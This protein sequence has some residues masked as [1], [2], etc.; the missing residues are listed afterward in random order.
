MAS[1]PLG[2]PPEAGSAAPSAPRQ[3][4]QRR[5]DIAPTGDGCAAGT[6]RHRRASRRRR[7]ERGASGAMADPRQARG[8]GRRRARRRP[9]RPG[10]RVGPSRHACAAVVA[11]GLAHPMARGGGRGRWRGLDRHRGR[12]RVL[13]DRGRRAAARVSRRPDRDLA[14]PRRPR[15]RAGPRPSWRDSSTALA[16]G[17]GSGRPSE[18]FARGSR[19]LPTSS[20]S[21]PSSASSPRTRRSDR[22]STWRQ[23][24]GRSLRVA[25]RVS[26]RESARRYLFGA[27][28]S[29]SLT[30]CR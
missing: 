19:P 7:G 20:S 25:A 16:R 27:S 26:A 5:E 18:R 3:R 6:G 28:R 17:G 30:L 14:R 11:R 29:A 23:V 4:R 1:R 13:P 22:H 10:R 2:A 9:A 21:A 12:G 24:I 15:D 8:D